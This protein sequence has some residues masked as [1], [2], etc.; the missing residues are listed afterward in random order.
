MSAVQRFGYATLTGLLDSPKFRLELIAVAG[1]E[2]DETIREALAE[3]Y[4]GLVEPWKQVCAEILRARRFKLRPGITLD[5]LVSMPTATA[6]GVALRALIDPG[7]GVVDHTG[8]RSLLGTAML[9]LLVGCTEPADV[10][11]GT[12]LEQVVQDL[13]SGPDRTT[14]AATRSQAAPSGSRSR[15]AP[16]DRGRRSA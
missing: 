4:L 6:E 14:P 16:A 15:P 13:H 11:G 3:N 8:R 10:I 12:S 2:E 9:A 7:V 5:T 1:A